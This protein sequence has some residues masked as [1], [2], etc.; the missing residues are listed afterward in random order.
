MQY[1]NEFLTFQERVRNLSGAT[2]DNYKVTLK[3]FAE[4]LSSRATAN[5]ED[6][7]TADVCQF[8]ADE[9]ARGCSASSCNIRL[10]ALRNYYDYICRF[11]G[12]A[13]NPCADV[14]PMR[15]PRHLPE[16]IPEET[17]RQVLG[18]FV[19]DSWHGARAAAIITALYMCGFRISE[20][21][22]LRIENVDFPRGTIR[23]FGKGRKERIVPM[24]RQVSESI[25]NWLRFRY[26]T[27]PEVFTDNRGAALS[28]DQM[29][30][31]IKQSLLPY[32]APRLAHPHALRHSFATTLINHGVALTK[33]SR[34]LGHSSLSTT[35]VYISCASPQ[36]NPFDSL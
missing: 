9:R 13:N 28:D 18:S 35:Y 26:G 6:V 23:V 22:T 11:Q 12:A 36:T 20:L 1:L 21:R 17:M 24:S 5:V 16:A 25:R 31:I 15:T 3:I 2:L 33:I 14:R 29:R 8:L 19:R 27:A 30:Y 34:M 32:V 4:W 10:S 7:T